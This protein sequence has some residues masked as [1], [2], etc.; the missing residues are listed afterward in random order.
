MRIE[1]H[2]RNVGILALCQALLSTSQGLLIFLSGL[3]GAALAGPALATLPVST[4][5]VGILSVTIPASLLM[6]RIGRR[7]GFLIGTALGLAGALTAAAAIYHDI[8]ALFA[9]GTFLMGVNAGFGQFYRFAA[10]DAAP[11]VF[12]SRAISLVLAGG[13]VAAFSGPQLA[14]ATAD[15][16][17]PI[18]FLGA[19]LAVAG[20]PV[21]AALLLLFLD[22]PLPG[23]AE[24]DAPAR[25]MLEILRQPAFGVAVLGGMVGYGVMSLV[26][27]A[28]PL[29]MIGCGFAFHDAAGV[30]QWHILAMFAPSFVTGSII[31]RF[32]VLQV[33]LAGMVLLTACTVAALAGIELA[34]FAVAL[35]A[36]GLGWNFA[37]VGASTLLTETY[38]PS[39]RAKVQGVN[40]FL[41]FGS[42]ASAS[43][44]SGALLHFLGWD[45]VQVFALPFVA[46]ATAAILWLM[47]LRRTAA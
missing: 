43:F 13:V 10:A 2:H 30:I 38:R 19:Y 17:A 25:P 7:A 34:N 47:W 40:D 9:L 12:R 14:K 21:L 22:I 24:R 42:V 44:S 29:A 3:V 18:P 35:I 27:T 4:N 36:L 16:L 1:R 11:A 5:V 39:E 28:T 45:A 33:M 26:M 8:F 23:T 37:F 32:G 20:L 15:L 31:Q 6:R 41:V 46:L